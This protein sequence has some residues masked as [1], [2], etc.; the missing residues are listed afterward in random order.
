MKMNQAQRF[1]FPHCLVIQLVLFFVVRHISHV[2]GAFVI[3][4]Q[5]NGV[6]S[7]RYGRRCKTCGNAFRPNSLGAKLADQDPVPASDDTSSSDEPA[8]E[9]V[10]RIDD[11]GSNLTDRFK[12]KVNALMGTFDPQSGADDERQEGNILNGTE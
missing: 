6:L 4:E 2:D 5:Q 11:H 8:T 1:W 7:Q 3:V 9:S 12:Y 10:I